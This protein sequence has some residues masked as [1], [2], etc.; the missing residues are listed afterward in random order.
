MSTMK[1]NPKKSA[2]EK[3]LTDE[4]F[5]RKYEAGAVDL[6]PILSEGLPNLENRKVSVKFKK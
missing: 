5:T 2:S 4:D 1:A 3:G 6:I